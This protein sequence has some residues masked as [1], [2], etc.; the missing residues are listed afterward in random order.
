MSINNVYPPHKAIETI[1]NVIRHEYSTKKM[2]IKKIKTKEAFTLQGSLNNI[3]FINKGIIIIYQQSPYICIGAI[4]APYILGIHDSINSLPVLR[5]VIKGCDLMFHLNRSTFNEL[6]YDTAF[7]SSIVE[8]MSFTT[9][10]LLMHIHE[11]YSR[12]TDDKIRNLIFRY[13]RLY[14]FGIDAGS[15]HSFIMDRTNLSRSI[16]AKKI[17]QLKSDKVID[18]KKGRLTWVEIDGVRVDIKSLKTKT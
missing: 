10:M 9:H 12:D 1:S 8:V 18:I 13:E 16:V 7:S 4:R 17:A 14:A 15:I 11:I 2:D 6:M 3:V 5:Y